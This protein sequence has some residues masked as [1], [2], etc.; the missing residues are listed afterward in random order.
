MVGASCQVGPIAC[1][2]IGSQN[3]KLVATVSD[4]GEA[5]QHGAN[6]VARFRS[7]SQR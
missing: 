1:A 3:N 4:K 7:A 6:P 5:E 2:T